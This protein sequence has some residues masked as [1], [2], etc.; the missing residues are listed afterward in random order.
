[1]RI[2]TITFFGYSLY[3]EWHSNLKHWGS[4]INYTNEFAPCLRLFALFIY[5]NRLPPLID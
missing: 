5:F 3:F 2:K 4:S 1:M